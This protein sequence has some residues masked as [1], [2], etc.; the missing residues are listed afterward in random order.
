MVVQWMSTVSIHFVPSWAPT[1]PARSEIFSS[2]GICA[3]GW[4]ATT[5]TLLSTD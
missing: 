2:E 4:W 5:L 1:T 3:S